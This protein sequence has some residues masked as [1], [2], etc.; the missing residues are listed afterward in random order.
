MSEK[1]KTVEKS[2]GA[3]SEKSRAQ[4]DYEQG[5][6]FMGTGD[7]TLAAAAFHNAL[8]EF[9]E[10]GDE[11]GMANACTQLGDICVGRQE[12]Q[13]ALGHYQK[14]FAICT[15]KDDQA[16]VTFLKKK[17]AAAR[18]SLGQYDEA[19]TLYVDLLDMYGGLNNPQGAV[20][21]LEELAGVYQEKGEGRKAAD[22]FRTAADIHANFKH[23]RHAA[24]LL[25]K[26]E[27]AEAAG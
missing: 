24:A 15:N 22:A 6:T 5:K 14:A 27:E 19:V 7:H 23:S 8:V 2:A 3:E 18:R 26:A 13:R 21:T 9:E 25:K 1:E 4:L 20:E 16:S 10:T 12:Y 17:M 11:N